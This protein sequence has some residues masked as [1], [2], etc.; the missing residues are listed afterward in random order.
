MWSGPRNLST[1]L[2]RR[3]QSGYAEAGHGNLFEHDFKLCD[4]YAGA[5]EAA[6]RVRCPVGLIVGAR[7]QMTPPKA[8]AEL[9]RLLQARTVMLPAGHA[10]MQEAPDGVLQALLSFL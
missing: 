4:G 7:D 6:A 2:M 10:L 1:A 9:A 5:P 3:M 8:A